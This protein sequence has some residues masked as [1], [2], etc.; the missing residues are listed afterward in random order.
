[1]ERSWTF[2]RTVYPSKNH[3]ITHPVNVSPSKLLDVAAS[4]VAGV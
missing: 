2:F 1:M 3:V 4:N